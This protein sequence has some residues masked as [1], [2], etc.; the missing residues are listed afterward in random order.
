M[1]HLL[2]FKVVLSLSCGAIQEYFDV[3][4]KKERS[5]KPGQHRAIALTDTSL[6]LG[7]L[8]TVVVFESQGRV[9]GYCHVVQEN[10]RI[11]DDKTQCHRGFCFDVNRKRGSLRQN[12][13]TSHC[14]TTSDW[15]WKCRKDSAFPLDCSLKYDRLNICLRSKITPR[16]MCP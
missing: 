4:V 7:I 14:T 16:K 3:S 12:R 8:F 15:E 1:C 10:S 11:F 13:Q 5:I 6:P 9:L 2:L